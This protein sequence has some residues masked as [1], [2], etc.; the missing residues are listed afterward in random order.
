MAGENVQILI[1]LIDSGE[2]GNRLK[3]RPLKEVC[4]DKVFNGKFLGI[5]MTRKGFFM[6]EINS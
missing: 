3:N 4:T 6:N 1:K 5:Q 2:K